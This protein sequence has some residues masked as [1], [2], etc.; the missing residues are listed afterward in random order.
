MY[1]GWFTG[2]PGYPH[3]QL[4]RDPLPPSFP[5]T[6][7]CWTVKLVIKLIIPLLQLEL[8]LRTW[9]RLGELLSRDWNL[10]QSA[11]AWHE[12]ISLFLSP[13]VLRR[14]VVGQLEG[15]VAPKLG[16]FA[17]AD[18]TKAEL[19]IHFHHQQSKACGP[20]VMLSKI[21]ITYGLKRWHE[22]MFV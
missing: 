22:P 12:I 2:S 18:Q 11:V 14:V 4:A 15:E 10:Y 1:R 6:I 3:V 20:R 7:T 17:K 9:M 13:W 19:G 16:E 8:K 21:F 5:T